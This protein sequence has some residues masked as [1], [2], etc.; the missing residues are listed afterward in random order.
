MTH[1]DEPLT[2]W[3][4]HTLGLISLTCDMGET[5]RRKVVP[6]KVLGPVIGQDW[7]RYGYGPQHDLLTDLRADTQGRVYHVR[8]P[9]DFGGYSLWVR[10]DGLSFTA[11]RREGSFNLREAIDLVQRT[12]ASVEWRAEPPVPGRKS[13][14]LRPSNVP[15]GVRS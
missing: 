13:A 6:T 15:T 11:S 9:F 4:I 5:H 14:G 7:V 3:G 1:K 8:P 10:E 12:Q 2:V